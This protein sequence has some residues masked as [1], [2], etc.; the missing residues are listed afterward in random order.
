ML[1]DPGC[2]NP[3]RPEC[4]NG[5]YRTPLGLID[6]QV[7]IA[8]QINGNPA[9]LETTLLPESLVSSSTAG[10]LQAGDLLVL[11]NP[12]ALIR[13][14]AADIAVFL[15]DL[16]RGQT[17]APLT[18][19][20]VIHPSNASV[21]AD[22]RFP[23]GIQ[24]NGMAF[25][26]GGGL[27]I[28]VSD[29][30]I[31]IYGAD[32]RRR[33]NGS[34]GFVDFAAGTGQDEF[35]I[36]VGLQDGRSR[37]F[38][39]HQQRG[40]VRRYTIGADGT[41][42]LDAVTGG[43]QFPVGIDATNSSTVI[44]PA[45]N[46]I[47]VAPTAV[48]SSQIEL[49]VQGGLVNARVSVFPDPREAEQSIPANQPLHRSLFLDE[50][51]ADF[52][53]IEVPAYARAFRLDNPLTGTPSFI[54]VEANSTVGV[55]G[56]I[57]HVAVE[58]P[59]LGYDPVCTDPDITKQ[60]FLFWAPDANDA[61]IVEGAKFIDITT[62]CGSILG[63]SRDMSYFL[64]GVRICTPMT[65]LV[66]E[67]LSGLRQVITGAPCINRQTARRLVSLMDRADRD[68]D[69]ARYADVTT[70]LQAIDAQVESSPQAFAGCTTN[71]GGEIQ[72]RVRS[73]I[74]ALSKVP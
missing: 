13:Y 62:G 42:T 16:G 60:P 33:S 15:A 40:E 31:L 56:V 17:P 12:G 48:L 39:T 28:P 55:S 59:I 25:T 24:P 8:T 66:S 72:A 67:K 3:G 64:T 54:V 10:V 58:A 44:A 49:V 36:S 21:P 4:L 22:Q 37:A 50:L 32:G 26:P 51:R 73:A 19:T 35:K 18:P 61:P 30:R 47:N 2:P 57:N 63:L 1:R 38:V 45:G 7:R 6:P 14:R 71:V 68:F 9:L 53:H 23:A 20:T 29:G 34:G 5:G 43:L 52:P 41:G 27:L 69:R 11:T 46:N 70:S 74:Y 65:A